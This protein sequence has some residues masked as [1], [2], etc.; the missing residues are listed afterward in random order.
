M[1]RATWHEHLPIERVLRGEVDGGGLDGMDGLEAIGI[2][3]G[4][5]HPDVRLEMFELAEIEPLVLH[6]GRHQSDLRFAAGIVEERQ[7]VRRLQPHLIVRVVE[8]LHQQRE[9]LL[10]LVGV[11]EGLPVFGHGVVADSPQRAEVN[12]LLLVRKQNNVRLLLLL[13][14]QRR[15]IRQLGINGRH[16]EPEACGENTHE[17]KLRIHLI[18]HCGIRAW[19]Q[20]LRRV[21]RCRDLCC[22][23]SSIYQTFP[24]HKEAI[25][26]RTATCICS[27]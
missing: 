24:R 20:V 12:R 17:A 22:M 13:R 6:V 8:P 27:Q 7:E 25:R 23:V 15:F 3:D 10:L 16:R 11:L 14:S 5:E 4:A 1:R 21:L 9:E 19:R 26:P 2:R 18:C